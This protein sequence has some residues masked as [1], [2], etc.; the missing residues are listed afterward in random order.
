M[1]RNER[2]PIVKLYTDCRSGLKDSV[3]FCLLVII[4]MFCASQ[5]I[6]VSNG[7]FLLIKVD[8]LRKQNLA[9]SLGIQK[10]NWW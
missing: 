9:S 5:D 8:V 6:L 1:R 4:S 3:Y 10:E 2:I 7:W